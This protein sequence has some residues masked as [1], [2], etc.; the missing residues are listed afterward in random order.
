[1]LY[2]Q[3]FHKLFA[4]LN[5]PFYVF[6]FLTSWSKFSLIVCFLYWSPL[7]N[8]SF[9]S[10]S[11]FSPIIFS[12][13]KLLHLFFSFLANGY[14]SLFEASYNFSLASSSR[15]SW[16][17]FILFNEALCI[18]S[19]PF[20]PNFTNCFSFLIIFMQY[21]Y[22][23]II[24]T[25]KKCFFFLN[26]FYTIPLLLHCQD[27]TDYFHFLWSFTSFCLV[28]LL[29]FSLNFFDLLQN[30]F[31]VNLP[32]LWIGVF[33]LLENALLNGSLSN[34]SFT[35]WFWLSLTLKALPIIFCLASS[36]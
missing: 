25:F 31:T 18:Y 27:L 28:S 33:A 15:F 24:D 10:S 22:C 3:D 2:Q 36:F 11:G 8:F 1:M 12:Y 19:L 4:F 26:H 16:I 17:V 5:D 23:S 30:S 20:L 29:R 9:A 14:H 34:L 6:F 13:F 32:F 21:L 7:R 35:S